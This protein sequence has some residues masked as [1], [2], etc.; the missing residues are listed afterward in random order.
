MKDATALPPVEAIAAGQ[1]TF[2]KLP[3]NVVVVTIESYNVGIIAIQVG[4]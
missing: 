2:R 4:G 1:P 3:G